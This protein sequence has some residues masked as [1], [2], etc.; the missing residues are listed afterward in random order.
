MRTVA[1]ILGVWTLASFILAPIIA[2]YIRFEVR[3]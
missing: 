1:I 3:K 2:R